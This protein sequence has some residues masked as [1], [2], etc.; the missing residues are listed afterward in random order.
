MKTRRMEETKKRRRMKRM[1]EWKM[2]E[3]VSGTE[4][5]SS[6]EEA[7]TYLIIFGCERVQVAETVAV[8]KVIRDGMGQATSRR[9]SRVLDLVITNALIVDWRG[10]YKVRPISSLGQER[11]SAR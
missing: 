7:S 5:R 3:G 9:S 8:G 4:P 2:T 1:V 11:D 6:L 10:I